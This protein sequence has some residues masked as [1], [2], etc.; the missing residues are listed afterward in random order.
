MEEQREA[1]NSKKKGEF[2][3]TA[4]RNYW[5]RD[6]TVNRGGPFHML[7]NTFS[8]FFIAII[9]L[10]QEINAKLGERITVTIFGPNAE[11]EKVLQ[12][13]PQLSGI[14]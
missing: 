4:E 13:P 9:R 12:K 6:P 7:K 10:G 3:I 5:E 11:I 8:R 1:I 14:P 2:G